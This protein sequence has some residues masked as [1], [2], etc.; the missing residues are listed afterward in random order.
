MTILIIILNVNS[1][2]RRRILCTMSLAIDV[3]T[4]EPNHR[5]HYIFNEH[6]VEL[7]TV[8]MY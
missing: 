7:H 2:F 4:G 3:K 8:G 6:D 5:Q 1:A